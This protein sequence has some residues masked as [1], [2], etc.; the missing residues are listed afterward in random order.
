MGI[1]VMVTIRSGCIKRTLTNLITFTNI[2]AISLLFS[3]NSVDACIKLIK[4]KTI[5]GGLVLFDSNEA[6]EIK[7]DGDPVSLNNEKGF[8]VGFHKDELA[9]R[10]IE[11]L[12]KDGSPFSLKLQPTERNYQTQKIDGLPKKMVTPPAHILERIT[13]EYKL[14]KKARSFEGN[15]TD[16]FINGF[17]WPV[18]GTITGVYGSQR[19]LNGTLKQPHFGIDIAAPIG[20]PVKATAS[21]HIVMVE[22]LYFT[23]WTVIISHGDHISSTY[24]HLHTVTVQKGENIK[25]GQRIGTVGS[26]G[27]STGPHLDWRI[28]L[29][30]RRLDPLIILNTV[31]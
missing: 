16:Y 2:F 20:E 21:G 27:R 28:N 14:V 15:S 29:L 1:L 10:T 31:R 24:S 5:Q 25:R 9:L 13:N 23:G 11:G 12:C 6:K 22:D 7:L 8:V 26:T 30:D 4:G 18:N 19:I 17:D 3:M